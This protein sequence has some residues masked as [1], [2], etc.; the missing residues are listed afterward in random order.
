MNAILTQP[1]ADSANPALLVDGTADWQAGLPGE[2]PNAAAGSSRREMPWP[3]PASSL[4]ARLFAEPYEFDFFQA[5]SLLERLEP[6]RAAVGRQGSPEGETVRFGAHPSLSFPASTVCD[7]R[8]DDET[9]IPL[10]TVAFLGLTGPSGA[11]P[12]FYSEQ[13]LRVEREARSAERHA[14]RDWLD[15]FNH[16]L[17]SLFFRA[18]EKYRFYVPAARGELRKAEPDLFTGGM[19]SLIGMGLP[20]L[21]N[22]LCVRQRAEV[23]SVAQPT[24]LAGVEDLALLYYSGLFSQRP[25]N[26]ANLQ[27]LVGDYFRLPA[28]VLQFQGQWLRLDAAN[29]S[30]ITQGMSNN[31]LGVNVVVGQRV[32]DVQSK[33]RIRLGPLTYRQFV[34]FLPEK[35]ATSR[36]KS[37]FLLSHLVRLYAG[38][39]FDFDVQLVLQAAEVPP[40]VLDS[41]AEV[42]PRLGWNTW[43]RSQDSAQNAEDAV[44]A[45]DETHLVN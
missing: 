3:L 36:S 30:Q 25:R 19:Y 16:R 26:A 29:Q 35:A 28:Q 12:R 45:G 37:L 6:H 42:G 23:A 40:T 27:A 9:G 7:L 43:L 10:L 39:E 8:R 14:L 31:Q 24:R 18:W 13:L 1:P 5:V 21:R 22:K 2:D 17:T 4:A 38:P 20:S 32:W 34:E 44:F 33:F 15:I 11:L 41:Q